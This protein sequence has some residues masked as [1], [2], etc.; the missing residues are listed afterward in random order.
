MQ[1]RPASSRN[2][3][4][5]HTDDKNGTRTSKTPVVEDMT[6]RVKKKTLENKGWRTFD[7]IR[8]SP[9]HDRGIKLIYI[10][11]YEAYTHTAHK[12]APLLSFVIDTFVALYL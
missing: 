9:M 6:S 5:K 7:E 8:F 11:M 10:Y 3:V 4:L 12:S 1:I 2:P